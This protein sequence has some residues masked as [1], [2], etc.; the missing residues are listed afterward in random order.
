MMKT[1]LKILIISSVLLN[2]YEMRAQQVNIEQLEEKAIQAYVN[3]NIFMWKQLAKKA[4]QILIN[5]QSNEELKI[6]AIKLKYG[7]LYGCLSNQD[8]TTYEQYIDETLDQ[9]DELLEKYPKSSDLY[10]ISSA[11]MSVQMAFSPMKGMT[12]GSL[13]GKHINQSIQLDSLNAIAWR[14]YASS[15]YFTPKMWG[16]DIQE[17]IR[18]YQLAIELFEKQNQTKN[19]IYI[20]SIVW[21]GIAYKKVGEYEKAKTE[22]VKALQIAPNFNWVKNQLLPSVSQI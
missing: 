18:T 8:K 3:S 19:W 9:L 14:Q 6:T 22:F 17:A 21:L 20:D 16:G 1:L 4:D 7:L 2:A 12:L 10:T 11:L 15:K 5:N 13:S